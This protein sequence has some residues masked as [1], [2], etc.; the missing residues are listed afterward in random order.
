MVCAYSAQARSIAFAWTTTEPDK[1]HFI[2][3]D[4]KRLNQDGLFKTTYQFEAPEGFSGKCIVEVCSSQNVCADSAVLEVYVAT[5]IRYIVA[6]NPKS[7]TRPVV[8]DVKLLEGIYETTGDKVEVGSPCGDFVTERGRWG[9]FEYY[10]VPGGAAV[11]EA[12]K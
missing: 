5:T 11:C 1:P 7:D 12:K 3:C 8:D 6:P 9:Q 2:K 10:K 4:G